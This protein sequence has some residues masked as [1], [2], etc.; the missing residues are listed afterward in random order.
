MGNSLKDGFNNFFKIV[1]IFGGVLQN[2]L[3]SGQI[4]FKYDT[5]AVKHLDLT[6]KFDFLKSF[7]AAWHTWHFTSFVPLQTIDDTTFAGVG[8][9]NQP[10]SDSSIRPFYFWK[11]FD[12]LNQVVSSD[13]FWRMDQG[14]S[15]FSAVSYWFFE[16]IEGWKMGA[17]V[18]EIRFE[19]YNWELSSQV[20][21]PGIGILHWDKVYLVQD[22]Y[23]L[24][25]R[26][27]QDF[28]FYVFAS[29]W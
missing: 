29:A 8:I 14:I 7:G 22:Y 27:W 10:N 15:H 1:S 25:V 3:I 23:D 21:L 5:R 16:E 2:H 19:H 11:L 9:A 20:T 17:L 6:I 24:F 4:F 26:L 12:Q 18:L 13:C 28:S